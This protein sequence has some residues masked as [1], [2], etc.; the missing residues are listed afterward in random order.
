MS[1][2]SSELKSYE[3]VPIDGKLY[4]FKHFTSYDKAKFIT[5]FRKRC[6]AQKL[7]NL[8][9]AGA[10]RE[11]IAVELD[12]FDANPPIRWW[13]WTVQDPEAHSFA[14]RMSL[15]KTYPTQDDIGAK[16]GNGNPKEYGPGE[17]NVE[18]LLMRIDLGFV[19]VR[20][21]KQPTGKTVAETYGI[22]KDE[23]SQIRKAIENSPLAD[24]LAGVLGT[25]NFQ[26]EVVGDD[27]R[28]ELLTK[29]FGNWLMIP[30][31]SADPETTNTSTYGDGGAPPN[32]DSPGPTYGTPATT[33]E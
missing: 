31:K 28:S 33:K 1:D 15:A 9:T 16:Y 29:L 10:T 4:I 21:I 8:R 11:E 30:K 3:E 17:S 6:K 2:L 27:A 12:A 19:N 32:A 20:T 23:I 26:E 7:E 25:A 5:E 24:K 13:G 22:T 18:D 14:W